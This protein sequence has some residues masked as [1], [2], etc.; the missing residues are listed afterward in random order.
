MCCIMRTWVSD[1]MEQRTKADSQ[2]Y[3]LKEYPTGQLAI[4]SGLDHSILS[5]HFVLGHRRE[6]NNSE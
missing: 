2:T 3:A 4:N 5:V 6:S 1:S